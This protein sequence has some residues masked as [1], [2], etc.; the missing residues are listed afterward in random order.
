MGLDVIVLYDLLNLGG[1]V[2]EVGLGAQTLGD[3]G[4]MVIVPSGV[5]L[6]LYSTNIDLLLID[7]DHHL[8]TEIG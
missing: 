1:G 6:I 8:Y 4:D 5:K 2:L 7:H 3:D